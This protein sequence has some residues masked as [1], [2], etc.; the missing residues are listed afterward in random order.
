M[1]KQIV[2]AG[3]I[4]VTVLIFGWYI[5]S[6]AHDTIAQTVQWGILGL[7]YF[8]MLL[9]FGFVLFFGLVARERLLKERASRHL[10]E[11]EASVMC[12]KANEGQQV[13]IRETDTS[14]IWRN[15]H[16]DVR[17]Q[18]NG[19]FTAPSQAELVTWQ[20][21]ITRHHRHPPQGIISSSL[22]SSTMQVDLLS[23]LDNVQRCLI[24]G[25]SDAGK[26]TLLQWLVSR[27][28]QN[29]KVIIIDPHAY[30][31]K[32]RGC[33]VVGTGRNYPEIDRALDALIRLMTKRY[34]EIGKGIVAEQAHPRITILIDEW[35][36]I[37]QNVKGAGDAIKALLT[38]SR[39]AAFS[40]FV[41]SHSDRA[42]PLGLAGEY[43]LKD[44]FAVVRLSITNG[45]RQATLDTGNGEV[46][47]NL[48]GPYSFQPNSS[49]HKE[50]PIQLKLEPNEMESQILKLYADG[51]SYNE[52]ARQ[53]YGHI[54]GKQTRR[55]KQVVEKFQST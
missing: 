50:T 11:R 55:I 8:C 40:V 51:V 16:L 49:T 38:E 44:G 27:R 25:A 7:T 48:P 45:Q 28:V 36:A 41:A 19:Q 29:S 46:L 15:A 33:I 26:T 35:R 54:G 5:D 37:V 30:P 9:A 53:V 39:K 6:I 17:I 43:D 52:I 34:D 20:T 14:A 12:I 2:P 32:W 18:A 22:P 24:V 21:Y 1:S 10:T 31:Q 13:Y 42:K 3:V 4:L 23:A 47:T